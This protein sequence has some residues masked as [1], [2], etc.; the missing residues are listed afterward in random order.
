MAHKR[1]YNSILN[2]EKLPID[3][4]N[5]IIFYAGPRSK[6][7]GEIIGPIGPT[8]SKRMDKFAPLLYENGVIAT[9]EKGQR[10]FSG[11]YLYIKEK[12]AANIVYI[13]SSQNKGI[14]TKFDKDVAYFINIPSSEEYVGVF[15]IFFVCQ[16]L[17]YYISLSL[18]FD[19]NHPRY[20]SK[21][22]K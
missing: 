12:S 10:T 20:L 13:K 4:K 11:G 7:E 17:A 16:L 3:I 22:V 21:V 9:I 2:N 6:K 5:S 19:I 15:Y 18:G 8:K 14:E 1:L